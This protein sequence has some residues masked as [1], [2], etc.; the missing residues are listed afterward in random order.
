MASNPNVSI[1]SEIN[2]IC[3]QLIESATQSASCTSAFEMET[4]I[5]GQ[6]L[7]LGAAA[8]RAFFETQAPHYHKSVATNAEGHD[9]RYC[10]E[11][12]GRYYSIY[13]SIDFARSYY[14]GEG[15]GFYA[16]DA[17]LNLPPSGQSDYGRMLMEELAND[18]SFEKA[19]TF[20]SKL[21][22][23]HPSTRA[24]QVAI[25]T[26][27]Q[28]AEEF[29]AQAPAP[30][31]CDEATIL[32]VE[33]DN[34]GVPLVK[35]ELTALL[36]SEH[37]PGKA[38][39]ERKREGKTKEATVVSVSTHIAFQRTPEQVRD[40]LFRD[41]GS[42]D[43]VYSD[44]REKPTFKRTWATMNGKKAGLKQ[45]SVWTEQ[46]MN[47]CIIHCI[48]LMDGGEALQRCADEEFPGYLRILDLIH[49]IQ[50]L[51]KAADAQFGKGN[52]DGWNWVYDAVLRM[53]QGQTSQII[54]EL[55]GWGQKIDDSKTAKWKPIKTSAGYFE[56]NL[57]SMKYNEYLEKGFPIATGIIE[58]ACRHIIK[59]R[60]EQSGMR[61]T[62]KG[63]EAFLHL[64]C[65]H[66]NGDWNTYHDF[67]I[68]RRQERVYGV[69]TD[70]NRG[71]LKLDDLKIS[72]KKLYAD[73]V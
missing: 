9:L 31:L 41:R 23:I 30:P 68:R 4:L 72:G 44:T 12:R 37:T 16:M 40:S 26:D 63:V 47:P 13:G 48:M 35:S 38:K 28:D 57:Q 20:L 21:L 69:K 18:M 55:L 73:A 24:V 33:A 43:K 39:G 10:G 14:C 71:I 36:S 50:Y 59:D 15:Q 61:W 6:L 52:K 7:D 67:R 34:K 17:G 58:G 22:R 45:A 5:F 19:T 51:W 3:H 49:A 27:S 56:K 53:L 2:S 60:C 64:R 25:L 8:M 66:Q 11:R 65:I 42:N 70:Q 32:A 29:Y 46:L 62:L 54:D 1:V